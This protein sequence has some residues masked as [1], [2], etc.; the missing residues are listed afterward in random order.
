MK[1]ILFSILASVVCFGAYAQDLS[2]AQKAAADAAQTISEA[3]KVE[4][5][6]EKPKYWATSLKTQINVG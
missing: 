2:D 1:K 5:K 6:V 4:P 3:P